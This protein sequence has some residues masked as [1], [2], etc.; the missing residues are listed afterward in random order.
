MHSW[1]AVEELYEMHFVKKGKKLTEKWQTGPPDCFFF[2][3]KFD[4]QID[5]YLEQTC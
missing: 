4:S 5:A 3:L 2:F 1:R